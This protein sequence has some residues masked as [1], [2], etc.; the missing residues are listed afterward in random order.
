MY[1]L[2]RISNMDA[3]LFALSLEVA[4]LQMRILKGC[5]DIRAKS[6]SL[7]T[8]QTQLQFNKLLRDRDIVKDV[9]RRTLIEVADSGQWYT[10][11]KAV[12]YLK[13]RESSLEYKRGDQEQLRT[14]MSQTQQR[15]YVTQKSGYWHALRS[16]ILNI[17]CRDRRCRALITN[18]AFTLS[19]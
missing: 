2:R 5:T 18:V 15:D 9:L 3:L 4:L 11:R 13:Q 12:N 10:L 14:M 16:W 17:K 1:L 6:W 19:C 8:K 7:S